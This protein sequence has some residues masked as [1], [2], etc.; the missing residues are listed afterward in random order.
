MAPDLSC[1]LLHQDGDELGIQKM[2]LGISDH[3]RVPG[4][5]LMVE[6]TMEAEVEESET[7]QEV[8]AG[9]RA[10]LAETVWKRS[11]QDDDSALRHS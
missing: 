10:G 2:E 6:H 9:R 8:R 1:R 5:V 3:G 11:V 4:R 7:A